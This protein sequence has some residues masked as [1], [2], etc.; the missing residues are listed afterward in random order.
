MTTH[1][2]PVQAGQLFICGEIAGLAW[3]INIQ[4]LEEYLKDPPADFHYT[5]LC[6]ATLELARIAQGDKPTSKAPEPA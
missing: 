4:V 6:R 3:K 1:C 5:D 2:T